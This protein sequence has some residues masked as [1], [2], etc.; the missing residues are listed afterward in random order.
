M[1]QVS[2]A[3]DGNYFVVQYD[4]TLTEKGMDVRFTRFENSRI[5]R[6]I[7]LSLLKGPAKVN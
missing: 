5:V 1:V 2:V 4:R 7:K 6:A 3:P